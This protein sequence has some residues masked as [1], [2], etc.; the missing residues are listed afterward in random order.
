MPISVAV[1]SGFLGAGKTK[2][3]KKMISEGIYGKDL[4]I[5]ENEFGEVP[6]DGAYLQEHDIQI[7]EI[8]SGCICCSVT[9]DFKQAILDIVSQHPIKQMIIEPSG[10]AALS[11]VIKIF[12]ED[13]FKERFHLDSVITVIDAIRF[14][15][16]LSNFNA[17]YKNQIQNAR[18][19]VL[20]RTQ[21][22][23]Q[24][25]L[26]QIVDTLKHLNGQATVIT[27][28]WEQLSAKGMIQGNDIK[29][30]EEL[31]KQVTKRTRTI[32][33]VSSVNP[34]PTAHEVFDS[35]G[36]EVLKAVDKEEIDSKLKSL[37]NDA[38]YGEILRAKG[39]ATTTKGEWIQFDY[40]Q[41]EYEIRPMSPYYTTKLCIIGVNLKKEAL[42]QLFNG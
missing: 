32:K 33:K 11:D 24:E 37:Q 36:I 18:T 9:G 39:I 38:Q 30:K 15:M 31:I 13:E 29:F 22:I 20:S 4:V 34:I 23:E 2:L 6:I 16:Y 14:E 12:K 40:V 19:I 3:I 35:F 5:I 25:K 7:K 8:A 28:P 21:F 1:F 41:G 17:F 27:T 42:S 26:Q 10:V